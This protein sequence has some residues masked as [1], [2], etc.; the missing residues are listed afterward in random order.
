MSSQVILF[1]AHYGYYGL[2]L[3]LGV[4]IMGIPLPDEFIMTYVGFLTY[5]GKLNPVLAVASAAFGSMS[6]ITVAYWLGRLFHDRVLA[7]LERHAGGERLE[8]VLRWY[9]RQGGK[10]LTAGYFIP[11]V[12]HLSGYVAGLSG[13]PYPGFAFFAYLGALLWTAAFIFLG[14]LLGSRWQ[15]ILP[16]IHRYAVLM[17]IGAILLSLAF[18]LLYKNR[19]SWS[20]GL[21]QA[22]KR[23]TKKYMSLGK[24]RF[25]VTVGGL[26]F[27]T[28]FVILAGLIQDLV[29]QEVGQFD[30]LVVEW[31]EVGSPPSVIRF[32]Q[33]VNALGTHVVIALVFVAAV[34][35]FRQ[36][37]RDWSPVLPLILAWGGGTLI[38]RLFQ[39]IFRGA[40]FSVWEDLTPLQAPS[41]GFLLGA[42]SFY[43]VLGY[44]F[45]RERGWSGQ[46]LILAGEVI[47]LTLLGVSPVYLRLHPPSATVTGWVVSLLWTLV[48]VFIYEFWLY[49]RE[50]GVSAHPGPR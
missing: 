7:Y 13:L 50:N 28:L 4:S 38:D 45:G 46:G 34:L 20:A 32:M 1:I 24:R 37:K 14:R 30:R 18:Y 25:A 41:S 2:Y 11:G 26:S 8:K 23:W 36:L 12:R 48:C 15:T 35:V 3:V 21:Y 29:A 6:G 5:A 44:I 27:V 10:L 9:Q 19:V 47:L 39:L 17:G 43:A 16:V 31:L 22:F 49:R 33:G 40:N 42:I